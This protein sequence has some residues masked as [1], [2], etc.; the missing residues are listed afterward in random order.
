ML[1]DISPSSGRVCFCR[2]AQNK[3]LSACQPKVA[4]PRCTAFGPESSLGPPGWQSSCDLAK[5]LE[6]ALSED[7][8]CQY[9][10]SNLKSAAANWYPNLEAQAY[11]KIEYAKTFLTHAMNCCIAALF[12]LGAA[13]LSS[14]VYLHQ[15]RKERNMIVA[16]P[17]TC[18][19][20]SCYFVATCIFCSLACPVLLITGIV[21][22]TSWFNLDDICYNMTTS[23][24]EPP[25]CKVGSLCPTYTVSPAILIEGAM[26]WD[27]QSNHG[28]CRKAAELH[29][30]ACTF[31]FFGSFLTLI[32]SIMS[33][34]SICQH[35]RLASTNR[36]AD[37][38][39]MVMV[40][41]AGPQLRASYQDFSVSPV[42]PYNSGQ[43][44]IM[45]VA[46]PQNLE[47]VQVGQPVAPH[48]VGPNVLQGVPVGGTYYNN[49]P[50]Q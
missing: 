17:Q 27:M 37:G 30:A 23:D 48:M 40:Q 7:P 3:V 4:L 34:V 26:Y 8:G 6:Q 50:P 20:S 11:Q 32:M 10:K 13:G 21:T 49:L 29:N 16:P 38:T 43:A 9:A 47:N 24:G 46:V 39:Q 5:A 1:R 44:V 42:M 31:L 2:D 15:Q 45:G 35:Q 25:R 12:A 41:P 22:A 33:C 18:T 19:G 28:M 36:A 14:V